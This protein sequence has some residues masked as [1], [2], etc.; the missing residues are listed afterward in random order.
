MTFTSPNLFNPHSNIQQCSCM[1]VHVHMVSL[2]YMHTITVWNTG[3]NHT[4]DQKL[5][6]PDAGWGWI[7]LFILWFHSGMGQHMGPWQARE[8][9]QSIITAEAKR[10]RQEPLSALA[11]KV[12]QSQSHLLPTSL[13]GESSWRS[14]W[15]A[16]LPAEGDSRNHA[17]VRSFIQSLRCFAPSLNWMMRCYSMHA[18]C[19][20][21]ISG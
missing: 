8:Q 5:S 21:E 15:L 16:T 10:T 11:C 1:H 13:R 9:S 17:A 20:Y 14:E 19:L 18:F 6:T 12:Q 4:P 3:F 2:S 7:S